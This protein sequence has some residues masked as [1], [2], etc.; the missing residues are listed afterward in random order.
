MLNTI[1]RSQRRFTT[2]IISVVLL[3]AATVSNAE[4]AEAKIARAITAA[5]SD[6][7]NDATIMDVDG[8]I[9]RAGTNGWICLPGVGLIPDD[10]HPMCNDAVWMKWMAAAAS[11]TAFTTDV[12]GVAYMMAGDPM[13][14]NDNPMATDPNDDGVW[15][16]EGP[17]IMILFPDMDVVAD[18]P[19]NPFVGGPYVTW[20]ETPLAH[21]M[22]P[23]A[24]KVPPK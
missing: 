12:I 4:T 13:M 18:L 1:T 14:N 19:R 17:H 20:D 21:V 24:A 5:P 2:A 7:T 23:M 8:T 6:I 9:L 11:G 22:L 3:S 15:R 10:Q 16:Q